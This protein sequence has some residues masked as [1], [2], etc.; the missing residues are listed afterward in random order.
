ME[1]NVSEKVYHRARTIDIALGQM[2]G[3]CQ[4]AFY[5][6]LGY[7]AYIGNLGFKIAALIV[8]A[9]IVASRFFDGVTDPLIA[10]I[11]EKHSSKHGKLRLFACIGWALMAIATTLMCN[12]LPIFGEAKEGEASSV[13][14]IILFILVYA[15]YIIGYT[16]MSI[17][18]NM[19]GN[20]LTND[21]KQRPTLS[22]WSVIYSYL[23]PMVISAIITVV[24][25]PK[26]GIPQGE[27]YAWT[28]GVFSRANLL[29]IGVSFLALVGVCIGLTP[30]DKPENF[31]GTKKERKITTKEMFSLLKEN[32]ELRKYIIA[33][34]SDKLAQTMGS[35]A[36]VTTLMFSVLLGSM[37]GSYIVSLVAMMPSIVFAIIGAKLAQKQGNKKVMVNWTKICIIWNILFAGYLLFVPQGSGSHF[38]IAFIIFFILML[39]NNALK[40]VVSS[41]TGSM[42]MDV[43]DYECYRSGNYLPA[44]VSATYS[45]I[46]KLVSAIAP[47]IVTL[48]LGIAYAPYFK[49]NPNAGDV[50]TLGIRI[51]TAVVFCGMPILGWVCTLISMKKYSLTKERM[52]EI[53]TE[54]ADKK[55]Q[56]KEE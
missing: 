3:I 36:V 5:V 6:I 26:H 43:V 17:V 34:T 40:M 10:L 56:N 37:V 54:I 53:Q 29:V 32:K 38:G 48:F 42:R 12:A 47:F 44:T 20:I 52:E 24:I 23:A 15:I 1:N 11:I 2:T 35:Q 49:V 14:G 39:G 50:L 33:A 22:I 21:P 51:V 4:M 25:L 28:M 30:Y 55:A 18:G 41:A 31:V 8:S 46:D 7:A 9:I 45:F 13:V 16:F 27:D 19:S